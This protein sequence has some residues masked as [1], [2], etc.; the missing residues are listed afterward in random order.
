VERYRNNPPPKETLLKFLSGEDS[1]DDN[2]LVF[3]DDDALV[4]YDSS[5]TLQQK[6]EKATS[7]P[8]SDY[9]RFLAYI[10][11]LRE[12]YGVSDSEIEKCLRNKTREK[13]LRYIMENS[14]NDVNYELSYINRDNFRDEK[15]FKREV[16][17]LERH[18]SNYC[19]ACKELGVQPKSKPPIPAW[20]DPAYVD[21][22]TLKIHDFFVAK[23][24]DTDQS[25]FNF[26]KWNVKSQSG[27]PISEVVSAIEE[28]LKFLKALSD[29]LQNNIQ[30]KEV[31]R[32]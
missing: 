25:T 21:V 3:Y 11:I 28:D 13:R 2:A 23:S 19:F 4:F 22:Y 15:G 6:V 17:D 5:L 31:E 12:W 9:S 1:Y 18:Y 26:M 16:E 10:H 30:Q 14:W 8:N 29:A 7:L 24:R 27:F 32:K 20:R